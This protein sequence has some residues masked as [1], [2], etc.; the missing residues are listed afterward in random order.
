M[1][2]VWVMAENTLKAM[3]FGG[4]LWP[5]WRSGLSRYSTDY[6]WLVPHFEKMLYDNALFTTALDRSLSSHQVRI[7][8]ANY[9]N[10]LL[11]YIDRDMTSRRGGLFTAPKMQTVKELKAS[12]TSGPRK[13][14]KIFL[15]EKQPVSL[16]L[17]TMSPR[18]GNFEGENI[19][20]QTREL[21]NGCQRNRHEP[22]WLH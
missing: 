8:F 11:H 2:I 6:R 5:D 16:F 1:L 17:F 3:K 13:R 20:H 4:S 12:S 9:A 22:W 21:W 14:L 10:D 7:E 18:K 15:E 19:L